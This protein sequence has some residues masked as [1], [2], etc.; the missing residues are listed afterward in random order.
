[1]Q[2]PSRIR[3]STHLACCALALRATSRNTPLSLFAIPFCLELFRIRLN[4]ERIAARLRVA[5]QFAPLRARKQVSRDRFSS[6]FLPRKMHSAIEST[7]GRRRYHRR[8]NWRA[9]PQLVALSPNYRFA[10]APTQ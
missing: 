3:V 7:R 9:R 10:S 6:D 4:A 1:M 8:V 5:R 2:F